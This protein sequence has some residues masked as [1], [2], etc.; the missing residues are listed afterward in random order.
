[1]TSRGRRLSKQT[2]CCPLTGDSE[3]QCSGSALHATTKGQQGQAKQCRA[4][5]AEQGL[6]QLSP[7]GQLDIAV[8]EG[9][10]CAECV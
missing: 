5:E 9:Q 10:G 4:G 3:S 2:A 8:G 7:G 1:M 6:Q